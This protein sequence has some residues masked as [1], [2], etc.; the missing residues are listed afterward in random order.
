MTDITTTSRPLRAD[1]VRNRDRL[2][3]VAVRAFTEDGP[4]VPLEQIAAEAGVGVG[5]LY[6][7][8]PNRNALVA[9]V[10]R[11]EVERLCES[12]AELLAANPADVAMQE[13]MGR[14]VEYA[15]T[16]RGMSEALS[17]AVASGLPLF[18][19]TRGQMIA[20]LAELI[21][22]GVEGGTIRSDA[23][24]EDVLRAMGGVWKM[25]DGWATGDVTEWRAQARRLLAL[26]MDGLRYG[27]A[28]R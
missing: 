2:L 13:W 16:K 4:D 5:T 26:L 23:D 19:R 8:F 17:A 24:P 12:P 9:A 18:E 1:A 15:A 6:R 25:T 10:Y 27:A 28:R 11:H 14:F 22:A 3:E 21:A 20:A 7:H